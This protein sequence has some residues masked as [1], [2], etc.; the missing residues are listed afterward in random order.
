VTPAPETRR[1]ATAGSAGALP[2]GSAV[3]KTC[4]DPVT[5]ATAKEEHRMTLAGW[6]LAMRWQVRLWVD[7]RGAGSPARIRANGVG[8]ADRRLIARVAAWPPRMRQVFTLRKVY[9]QSPPDIARRLGLSEA[10]V[11]RCLIAAALA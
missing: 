4:R 5:A 6:S 3:G 8:R 1:R 9:E 7:V 2:G 11:E 10:E